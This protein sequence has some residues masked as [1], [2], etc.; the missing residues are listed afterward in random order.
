MGKIMFKSL[1]MTLLA[2]VAATAALAAP[3][4]QAHQIDILSQTGM[5]SKGWFVTPAKD[6][7]W[8]KW[9][10]A[11]TD[12]DHDG[13]VELFKAKEAGLDGAA[14]IQCE[15]MDAKTL[16]RHWGVYLTGG[17]DYP[18][19]FS[20]PD[21]AKNPQIY[22][23]PGEGI[24]YY[25]FD[26]VKWQTEFENTTKTYAIRLI[27]DLL[28]DEFAIKKWQLSGYD[29]TE[30]NHYYLPGWLN[31]DAENH[32]ADQPPVE[33]DKSRYDN[34]LQEHL[35]GGQIQQG[36]IGW[37]DTKEL[38]TQLQEKKSFN[39]LWDSYRAFK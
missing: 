23:N 25:I 5:G 10:Y 2:S 31:S 16:E 30:T 38:L 1:A 37:M 20:A 24:Y 29:G 6:K 21:S 3:M 35:G 27:G 13:N 9:H 22:A 39:M 26:S 36:A 32:T 15:E 8:E 4:Q 18:D 34:L 28:I 14:Y 19:I 12:L 7:D 11:I 17:S 33:I